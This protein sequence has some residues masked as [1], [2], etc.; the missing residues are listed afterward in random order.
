MSEPFLRILTEPYF[1]HITW[2]SITKYDVIW[3][4]TLRIIYVTK[5]LDILFFLLHYTA[6]YSLH[7]LHYTTLHYTTLHYTTPQQVCLHTVLTTSW[8]LNIMKEWN[9]QGKWW[10]KVRKRFYWL[11]HTYKCNFF[12]SHIP[13]RPL[14]THT[15]S[16][17]T[18]I[19][20]LHRYM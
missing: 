16:H 15:H 3:Y 20:R 10:Q 12:Y 6:L 13:T 4:C 19:N 9:K 1:R 17:R 7:S 14:H 11:Y 2:Y 5:K 8:L 18:N